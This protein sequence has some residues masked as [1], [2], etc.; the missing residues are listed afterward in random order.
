MPSKRTSTK[1]LRLRTRI[2]TTERVNEELRRTYRLFINKEITHAEMSRRRELLVALRSGMADPIEKPKDL[3]APT[4]PPTINGILEGNA[5]TPGEPD[6]R[7]LLPFDEAGR[8]W[9]AHNAGKETWK[10]YLTEIEPMLTKAQIERLSRVPALERKQLAQ[11]ERTGLR[12][13]EAPQAPEV[14]TSHEAQ[15]M[16]LLSGMSP[17]ELRSMTLG[18]M[19]VRLGHDMDPDDAA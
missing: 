14:E 16:A 3:E 11:Q 12:L 19:M 8:A 1:P 10:M 9:K 5:F 17:G 13:V 15:L 2:D 7:I 18:E 4:P 6:D